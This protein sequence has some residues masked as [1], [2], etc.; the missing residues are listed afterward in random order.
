VIETSANSLADDEAKKNDIVPSRRRLLV[1]GMLHLDGRNE[2]FDGGAC[3][4]VTVACDRM[5][6]ERVS[7]GTE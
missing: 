2:S 4:S 1:S 6:R 7:A 3:W 5:R